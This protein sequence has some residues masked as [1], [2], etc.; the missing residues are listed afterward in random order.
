MWI[1]TSSASLTVWLVVSAS[2]RDAA[3]RESS[4]QEPVSQAVYG[5]LVP[6]Q[7]SRCC[8]DFYSALTYFVLS[9]KVKFY[10]TNIS[11][12]SHSSLLSEDLECLLQTAALPPSLANFQRSG[13]FISHY[14]G[15]ASSPCCYAT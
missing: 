5:G 8:A 10:C 4:P 3:V 15:H 14:Y 12:P 1:H 6:L 7:L 2:V 13:Q 9:G 11:R